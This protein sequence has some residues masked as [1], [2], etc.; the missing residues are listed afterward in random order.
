MVG[1]G[2]VATTP[3]VSDVA[4]TWFPIAVDGGYR[5]SPGVYV[6]A[7]LQWGPVVGNDNALCGAC[8]FRYDLQV[9][10]DLR[11][12]PFPTSTLNPWVSYGAGWELLH[13]AFAGSPTPTATYQGPLVCDFQLGLDV[14]SRAVAVGPYLG[15]ALGEFVV[16]SLDPEPRGEPSL[17][18]HALHEWFTV[19]VRG[20]YGPWGPRPRNGGP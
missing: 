16:R 19:G 18:S 20:S 2:S 6:G 8:S 12:Y 1:G 3:S 13:L 10:A 15:V 17:E 9:Q 14:R 11:F 5:I 4:E 7:T